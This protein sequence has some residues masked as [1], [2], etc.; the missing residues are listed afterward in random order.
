T[1][2]SAPGC[3]A[4]F[5][6]SSDSVIAPPDPNLGQVAVGALGPG[7]VQ[8]VAGTFVIPQALTPSH[9]FIGLV[10]DSTQ[11]VNESNESNNVVVSAA[12][13]DVGSGMGG[14]TPDLIAELVNGPATAQAG[15]AITVGGRVRN[16]STTNPS[17]PCS[18][19]FF[20]SRDLLRDPGDAILGTVGVP[21]LAPSGSQAFPSQNFFIPSGLA[22]G[23][24]FVG[25]EADS[26]HVVPE[27]NKGNNLAFSSPATSVTASGG[28]GSPD[29]VA[30]AVSGPGTATAGG[31]ISVSGTVR[32]LSTVNGSPAC[33]A[34]FVLS[35]DTLIG[36][37]D[38]FLGQLDVPALPP[39]GS[40][41]FSSVPLPLPS[42]IASGSYFIGLIADSTQMVAESNENNN[43]SASSSSVVVSGGTGG[44]T[45][46]GLANLLAAGVSGPTSS[47]TNSPMPVSGLIKNIGDAPAGP[48]DVGFGLSASGT[49]TDTLNLSR[50]HFDGM[51]PAGQI[52]LNV[53]VFVP[54]AVPPGNY[55][56]GMDVD[57]DNT[58]RESNETDNRSRTANAISIASG[59]ATANT[60]DLVAAG[61]A[62]P[63]TAQVGGTIGV[64][65]VVRNQ[66]NAPAGNFRVAFVLS[67]DTVISPADVPLGQ[68]QL[69]GL[70]PSSQ[71][72]VTGS[73]LVPASLFPGG[74][75]VGMM[76]DPDNVIPESNRANN[77]VA[78]ATSMQLSPAT[79][80]ALADLTI[81]SIAA[82]A[83]VQAGQAMVLSGSVKN[84][85][86]ADAGGFNVA[87]YLSLDAN[88][89]PN[90]TL[91][92]FVDVRGLAKGKDQFFSLTV[93]V[94]P[95]IAAGNYQVLAV[96]DSQ[97]TVPETSEANNGMAS[98]LV[99]V[100]GGGA[101]S[102]CTGLSCPDLLVD[103]VFG[104]A[105]VTAGGG[106]HISG[107]VLNQG[108]GGAGTFG[109]T[110]I[111]ST[112]RIHSPD[113]A[114][115]GS[116]SFAGLPASS[117]AP[118]DTSLV[119]PG[120]LATGNYYVGIIADGTMTVA[121][122][123]ENNNDGFSTAQV[124]VAGVG[125]A[126]TSLPDLVGESLVPPAS[127][128]PGALFGLSA[129]VR[130]I[131]T[132]DAPPF[133]VQ[134]LLMPG[135]A[136]PLPPTVLG[137]L[138][139]RDG[140]RAA[141]SV[142]LSG[143]FAVPPVSPGS[144]F[145]AMKV[146]ANND[147]SESNEG[148]N[149]F[150]PP[151]A[152]QVF[153]AGQQGS[154]PELLPEFVRG[155][156]TA[157][158]G[159]AIAVSGSV[160]NAG[161][162]DAPSFGVL[163]VLTQGFQ[164]SP[165]D[166]PLGRVTLPGLPSGKS[167]SIDA[168]GL[169]SVPTT[170]APGAYHVGMVVDPEG[171]V[172]E[173]DE[174]NNSLANPTTVAIGASG[175]GSLPDL[176]SGGVTAPS[177]AAF[178]AALQLRG[179]IGN[180]GTAA[181]PGTVAAFTLDGGFQAAGSLT[182]GSGRIR[183]GTVPVASL[184][185][186]AS[187]TVSG[188]FFLPT[189]LQPGSYQV[190]LQADAGFS[191]AESHEENNEASA[192]SAL[193]VGL[194]TGLGSGNSGQ[195][196]LL[197]TAVSGPST[198]N[199]GDPIA[200]SATIKN[201]G[202]P[203]PGGYSIGFRL[204]K[205]PFA[206]RD[207]F[208]LG[209]R[210]VDS[211]L[212]RG[213]SM[214]VA[215]GFIAPPFLDAGPYFLIAVADSTNTVFEADEAN[216][217]TAAPAAT[218]FSS[219]G[220]G[221][222]LPDLVP[223]GAGGPA[224][225]LPGQL[226][227][228]TGTLQ[229]AGRV[230]AGPSQLGFAL[231]RL[232]TAATGG[233][234]DFI[235]LGSAP[236]PALAP[237]A[238]QSVSGQFT[239]PQP[240]AP[241]L[242]GV[243]IEV[244]SSNAVTE[245]NEFNNRGNSGNP[246][247][248][249]V[250][251]GK[252]ISLVYSADRFGVPAG[253]LTIR[254]VFSEAAVGTPTIQIDRP[255]NGND[256]RGVP[257]TPVSPTEFT[258][259]YNVLPQDGI[260]VF[261]GPATVQVN[262]Q[263]V[264]G[265]AFQ[266]P[267]DNVLTI[268]TSGGADLAPADLLVSPAVPAAGDSIRI[269][270][271]VENR[272][273]APVRSVACDILVDGVPRASQVVSIPPNG[274]STFPAVDIG[275]LPVGEHKVVLAVDPANQVAETDETNNR[276]EREL[277]VSGVTAGLRTDFLVVGG[278]IRRENG[279]GI[280]PGLSVVVT[281][282]GTAES[283]TVSPDPAGRYS[284]LFAGSGAQAGD[285]LSLRVRDA[286]GGDLPLAVPN[287]ATVRLTDLQIRQ[288]F[289]SIDIVV[290]G[291]VRAGEIN[292][293]A[294]VTI[295]GDGR[296]GFSGDGGRAVDSALNFP[297]SPVF[298]RNGDLYFCDVGNHRVRKVDVATGL[299]STIAGKGSPGYSGDGGTATTAA[300]N[301]PQA[302]A[303]DA[304]GRLFIADSKNHRVR[305]V[306]LS[307]GTI[308]T[309]AGT[310]S[311]GVSADGAPAAS[312]RLD[313]PTGLAFDAGGQLFIAD[314][315]NHRVVS[316]SADGSMRLFAGTGAPG[317]SGDQGQ[318]ALAQLRSPRGLSFDSDGNLL[319]ADAGNHRVRRVEAATGNIFTLAGTGAAGFAGEA[320]PA[321]ASP[322]NEPAG[323]FA[324]P[325]LGVVFV[326]DAANDRLREI[327]ADG[328]LETEAGTGRPG[329]AAD[330]TQALL[331]AIRRPRDV[332]A[333]ERGN[334]VFAD[335]GNNRIVRLIRA[336]GAGVTDD[337]PASAS[338]TTTSDD[339][340]TDGQPVPGV[341]ETPGDVDFFRFD[342]TA[343]AIY[344]I[345]AQPH[346]G[347]NAS[348]SLAPLADP[349][350]TLYGPDGQTVIAEGGFAGG[351]Q[352]F[353]EVSGGR[354]LGGISSSIGGV[355]ITVAGTYYVRVRSAGAQAIG[356]YELSVR[357]PTGLGGLSLLNQE[358]P[359]AFAGTPYGATLL[360]QG[361]TAPLHF[362]VSGALPPGLTLDPA[363]GLFSGVSTVAGAFTFFVEVTD[364]SLAPVRISRPYRIAVLPAGGRL[365]PESAH[366][367]PA[368]FDETQ[369]FE[370]EGDQTAID[371][372][373]DSATQVEDRFDFIHV[374]DDRDNEIPGSPFTGS[375]LAGRTVRVPGGKV[376]IR[377][378]SDQNICTY[379]FRVLSVTPAFDG[380]QTLSVLPP[381]LPLGLAQQPYSAALTA[382]GGLPPLKFSVTGGGLPPGLTLDDD[383]A[384]AGTP[385][386]A[387]DFD[388]S[389]GVKDA[390][391][392]IGLRHYRLAVTA[393]GGAQLPESAH[394]YA[395]N[396][397]R[398]ARYTMDGSPAAILVRFDART[399][400]EPGYDFIEVSDG[401]GLP[402]TG[403]PFTGRQLAGKTL[404]I[405]GATVAIRLRSDRS[406]VD[407][408]Y[409]V[410]SIVAA[411]GSG[412]PSIQTSTLPGARVGISYTATIATTGGQ[413][414]YF[415][416]PRGAMPPGIFLSPLDG[417]LFGTPSRSGDFPVGV[418]VQD[419]AGTAGVHRD[420]TLH[421]VS[422]TPPGVA[423]AFTRVGDS[424]AA[425]VV[426]T[427]VGSPLS[428]VQVTAEFD[429]KVLA[430]DRYVGGNVLD[431]NRVEL[432]A[433][434]TGRL[435]LD[436]PAPPAIARGGSLI[437][438]IFRVAGTLDAPERAVVLTNARYAAAAGAI[439]QQRP[440]ADPGFEQ[441][442]ALQ[443]DQ[444]G[445]VLPVIPDL[446][447]P[448]TPKPWITLDGRESHDS[449]IPPLPLSYAWTQVTSFPIVLSDPRSAVPTFAPSGPGIYEFALVADDGKLE[450]LPAHVRV[451]VNSDDCA[452]TADPRVLLDRERGTRSRPDDAPPQ[453]RVGAGNIVLDAS[454][455]V[456]GGASDAGRLVYGWTQTAGPSVQL[457]PSSTAAQPLFFPQQPGVY[458]FELVVRGPSGCQGS[459][460]RVSAIALERSDTPPRLA[461]QASASTTTAVGD[462]LG[463]G[464][465]SKLTRSLRVQ[466]PSTV[467]IKAFV[468][469]PD[470][471]QPPLRQRLTFEW[472][473]VAGPVVA[474]TTASFQNTD[475]LVS[476]VQ[477]QP[478]T[479]RVHIFE[480]VVSQLDSSG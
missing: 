277:F 79:S 422:V 273:S 39:S 86:Q 377:L 340:V 352:T 310:G 323:V 360:T 198:A 342:A 313:T 61:V 262:A 464:D 288:G 358:L 353:G 240:L 411:G 417:S 460:R 203:V 56:L 153:G 162:V 67:S 8:N 7:A 216:N 455:S 453:F 242:Y 201:A 317:F 234:G 148:N 260:D 408:G 299:L 182:P 249:G 388:L 349:A 68:L 160:R 144:Y 158:P 73:F 415:F 2:T 103:S 432:E 435:D 370:L 436:V 278:A 211:P 392:S 341:I 374:L 74:Y 472:A 284:A 285:T 125:G 122:S 226:V 437:V 236:V 75:F 297:C 421:I 279:T 335:T 257:M 6:L 151:A 177:T 270:G 450:S 250:T 333:D 246:I 441:Y 345:S 396:E 332:T 23:T 194:G 22:A 359:P 133:K 112:D 232:G 101:S 63:P 143:Q 59:G 480:C 136:S 78:Q 448:S 69:P 54:S 456:P 243:G 90:D 426:L 434:S 447:D 344:A 300:L 213:A 328:R 261:D 205:S 247:Q 429:P 308:E 361:G 348:A 105:S 399:S 379:G 264:S 24:Y 174:S 241:G 11:L 25:L 202:G 255:G 355:P 185:P 161:P 381:A 219:R 458:E 183:L 109:V 320:L 330:G 184:A 77:A 106:I 268:N 245:S 171:R 85:G 314:S 296:Q 369:E 199:I 80:G 208:A 256:L 457:S 445:R 102:T 89:S 30:E 38:P 50:V 254:A 405:L 384:I 397:D 206:I 275:Q 365:F 463:D 321:F 367:Y 327:D 281:N 172:A 209:E 35:T 84:I 176:V 99:T 189:Y 48:F 217:A 266:P 100:T 283:R 287:P 34:D 393:V 175:N 446:L 197:V 98:A 440:T 356:A 309:F 163:F 223:A 325:R 346:S 251:G 72:T 123:N 402:A 4:A 259:V 156:A 53:G 220:Q 178:G 141:A 229:N 276:L 12:T 120:S 179:T 32:N 166:V 471:G 57:I 225:A 311:T 154:L 181:A 244:D 17:P 29:L 391:G 319:I 366:P 28:G 118:V 146:D 121:E 410:E 424:L 204:A 293:E 423:L 476:A 409:R 253:A 302:L 155:P 20:L 96:A 140:L 228:L 81:G 428:D 97:N 390:S 167:Q 170:I 173:L 443:R 294:L 304:S 168:T 280:E 398:T 114:V 150:Q 362:A 55:F 412:Q 238:F 459:S 127:L 329:R 468:T 9:Y 316:V 26:G 387:G 16:L 401:L 231:V 252:Q 42:A 439:N 186:S 165:L 113:D 407:Y 27:S 239:I 322:L 18:A 169:L 191:V 49:F 383:G 218:V 303:F 363:A 403:S 36:P 265:G 139:V 187:A 474:L 473:Q 222:E 326:A 110:F 357:Q 307:L 193:A 43:T 425:T 87:L 427:D 41:V 196:D 31:A 180:I 442:V 331:A 478:T 258:V 449:N 188:F 210:F 433:Q 416:R 66:G 192:P 1:T 126:G 272:G 461:L 88:V 104:P 337:H 419:S 147:V 3:F 350:V 124:S 116:L 338:A 324:D 334:L 237:G 45:P 291:S 14:S 145:L 430:F 286:R 107:R 375:Q 371:V 431:G 301:E 33:K 373:F 351:P 479:S 93:A 354:A 267:F 298:T 108:G 129:S 451:V 134:F 406:I 200:V 452:P 292:P 159:T 343:G 230:T 221:A 394:N 60:A 438:L 128:S 115:L 142:P 289:A 227:Q 274:R 135:A 47:P 207:A 5:V 389:I 70:A 92:A 378:V 215:A 117:G 364:S 19:D 132:A 305:V 475:S 10:A 376:K 368:N 111:L 152:T 386:A 235:S 21:S 382:I 420:L 95:N 82:P 94:P 263:S 233:A 190:I 212:A 138:D 131:G 58:V 400:M 52:P 44:G 477:F 164:A 65:G 413:P 224:G 372:S 130:N 91:L 462:D 119:V 282:G 15:G 404:R 385:T 214:S 290:G 37:P 395:D 46:G 13:V 380:R 454:L 149:S 157:L 466:L 318:A 51:P 64:S 315:G 83:T 339:V 418:D 271:T 444:S 137:V 467:T 312:S 469:D 347:A 248:I 62:G 336:G 295:A 269:G 470:V 465:E 40:K 76:V 71:T 306:N 414:P 195:P